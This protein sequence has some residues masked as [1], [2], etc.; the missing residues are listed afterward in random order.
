MLG[1]RLLL[2]FFAIL[3]RHGP[4]AT[5]R[6]WGILAG[7]FLAGCSGD[8]G[9][10]APPVVTGP[11]FDFSFPAQGVS[12]DFQFDE[13]GD[14]DYNCHPHR[15]HGMVGTIHVRESSTKDSALVAVGEGGLFFVPDTVTIRTG[16]RI[17][18]VN[19]STTVDHT[20]SRP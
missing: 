13:A 4:M 20:A 11:T 16:G 9:P 14:W 19:V 6:L 12:H 10:A 2:R 3:G 17:R 5:K 1:N 18:W 15:A 8:D 7:L